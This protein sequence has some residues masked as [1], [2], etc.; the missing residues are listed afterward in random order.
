MTSRIAAHRHL[1]LALRQTEEAPT[2]RAPPAAHWFYIVD[3]EASAT[4]S[5]HALRDG[6]MVLGLSA[7]EADATA[8]TDA[9][10]LGVVY[11]TELSEDERQ[12]MAA[13]IDER[14][15]TRGRTQRGAKHE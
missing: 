7:T 9:D 1:D 8:A 15:R 12:S 5:A 10:G 6:R 4:E 13:R 14:W 11:Y 3:V 2:D